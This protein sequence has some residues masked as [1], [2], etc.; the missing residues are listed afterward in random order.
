M[1][2]SESSHVR[3]NVGERSNSHVLANVATGTFQ[4]STLPGKPGGPP[5]AELFRF[6]S[7]VTIKSVIR[8]ARTLSP[9]CFPPV[10]DMPISL[11][12][13]SLAVALLMLVAPGVN[14]A[15]EPP[16]PEQVDFFE[17]RIR[18]VLIKHC[19][20]C[21]SATA[22][23]LGGGL[24]LDNRAAIAKGGDSGAV[25]VPGDPQASRLMAALRYGDENLQ[26][27]PDGKLPD[28]ILAD[29]EQ[30]IAMGAPDPRDGPRPPPPDSMEAR[31]RK[32]WAFQK[33]VKPA[34]AATDDPWPRTD[35]D[36]LVWAR[37]KQQGLQPASTAAPYQLVRRLYFDLLGLPPTYEQASAFA[38]QP[39]D[40]A[41]AQLV[42]ELLRSPHFGERWGRHWLDV[43][44]FGDTKGYVF[45][46]DRNYPHA[47]KYRDWVVTAF[48]RDLPFDQF[49]KYQIAA[50]QMATD[51]KSQLAAGGFLTLGRRFL[52]N[53]HDLIDDRLDVVFR[54]TMGLTIGCTRCH[55]HKYDPLTMHDYYGLYGVFA[56]SREQQDD[57][58]PLRLVD[59]ERAETVGVFLR[60]SPSNRGDQATRQFVSFLSGN[61]PRPFE[62]GSGRLE[63][64]E[65][66]V[67]PDNPLTARVFVNRVWLQLFGA[68]LVRTPSDFGL[69]SD[70]PVHQ[71]ALDY[72]AVDFMEHGW[73]VKH[74]IR[75]IV[76][77]SV[78]RQQSDIR[79]EA[80]QS[81]P[82]NTLLWR[83]NRRRLDYEGLRDSWLAVS[84]Q[85][86]LTVGGASVR[87]D[88]DNP[89]RR[90]T[91]YAYL[92][93]QNLP[94]MFRTFDFASPDTH[95]P[96]RLETTVPQQALYLM[97]SAFAQ[98]AAGALADRL[99]SRASPADRLRQLYR[100][101]LARDPSAD[102]LRL[103]AEFVA[104]PDD[105]LFSTFDV[106]DR[107]AQAILMTNEF[108]FVD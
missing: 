87:I 66:I 91:L 80:A 49:L 21:H 23:E 45:M 43:A 35:L 59:K 77:S 38:A 67:S 93:R 53:Q 52:N 108:A 81:D 72:L 101:A 13:S 76:T 60:G 44:R 18:P 40:E 7:R 39:S 61:N 28:E 92:D 50:D 32:H 3:Q 6:A 16:T 68:G 94:S 42:D 11:R 97:N 102:E 46:E 84:G 98:T 82:E 26:M 24:M 22:R 17:A 10:T 106:W 47:F 74:L 88:G 14:S 25:L 55:D 29:F 79:P 104:V 103:G 54:G 62:R 86:D 20:E 12:F 33:P 71:D 4:T 5:H 96:Q 8:P 65:A 9:G 57:D 34:T 1:G 99:D 89:S 85:L 56:S 105:R 64:A 15:V 73:S 37:L 58:Q 75:Q 78:Y 51:D 63:L 27:P 69:R 90:R 48:N 36:R 2:Q 19:F 41:Y 83:M 31:A 95:A 107:L 30:W 100:F 70:P